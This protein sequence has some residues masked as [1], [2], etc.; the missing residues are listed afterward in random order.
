M[1]LHVCFSLCQ[2]FRKCRSKSNGKVCFGTI[3]SEYSGS[4]LEVVHFDQSD[5]S[6]ENLPLHFDKPAH[7]PTSFV[8]VDFTFLGNSAKE[9][10]MVRAISL[11]W[12]HLI[13][14]CCS[15]FPRHSHWSLTGQSG[16]MES[17][18]QFL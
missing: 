11:G 4:P 12:P 8:P 18:Q 2:N 1:R 5:R 7:C 13:G 10:E 15:I 16:I 9:L 6:D 17:T 14:K 3:R